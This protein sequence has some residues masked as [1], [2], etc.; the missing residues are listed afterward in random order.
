MGIAIAS[1]GLASAQGDAEDIKRGAKPRASGPWP[2][3]AN[4]WSTSAWCRPAT[5]VSPG[6]NGLARWQALAQLALADCLGGQTSALETPILLASC[7]GSAHE[8]DAESWRDAFDSAMLLAGTPWAG[9]CGPVFSSSCNSGLHALYAAKQILL[10]GQVDE[11][12][13]VAA[14]ILSRS[15]HDNFEVLRVLT[16]SPSSPWQSSSTGFILGE[17]AVALK[18]VRVKDDEDHVCVTGPVLGNELTRADGLPR[19]LKQFSGARPQLLLGQGTGPFANDEAEL[20]ALRSCF[21]RDVPLATSLVHFGHTLGASGLLSIALAALV[22]R[23][24]LPFSTLVMPGSLACDGRLLNTS[25]GGGSSAGQ[26]SKVLVSCLA[27]DGSCAAAMVSR[28]LDVSEEA[29]RR[30]DPR[31]E[32]LWPQ[33][34]PTGPLTHGT[35]R[36]LAAE[37][38]AHRPLDPPDVLMVH[39][40][41]PLAP[42]PQAS[43]GGRLLPSAVLEMTPGFVSQLI[44]RCWGFTGPALC[45]VG[46]ESAADTTSDLGAACNK[47]GLDTAHIHLHGTGDKREIEWNH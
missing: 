8:F 2:W 1:I 21:T 47:L 35:L 46:R 4:G 18:L 5:G 27:L 33:P 7:N 16:D 23:A 30:S 17:A 15:N 28:P 38:P 19:I 13:V 29:G 42:P 36:R 39:L 45:L 25:T 12:I 31:P 10:A 22:E 37:A 43:I 34:A 3:P 26:I 24:P 41:A 32:K 9:R 11:V 6:A 40:E 20:A 44:A 14:D